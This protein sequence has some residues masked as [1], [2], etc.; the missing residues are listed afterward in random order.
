MN[1]YCGRV[2]KNKQNFSRYFTYS[3]K[4]KYIFQKV[5]KLFFIL[6]LLKNLIQMIFSYIEDLVS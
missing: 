1:V 2:E 4:F 6:S 3:G 5:R